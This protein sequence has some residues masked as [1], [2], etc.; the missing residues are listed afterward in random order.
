MR[1]GFQGDLLPSS[2]KRTS[3]PEA[4]TALT[5]I[6]LDEIE[7]LLGTAAGKSRAQNAPAAAQ[8]RLGAV[9]LLHR[10]GSAL[11]RHV[12]RHARVTDGVFVAADS[13][14]GVAFLPARPL[15]EVDRARRPGRHPPLAI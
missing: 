4:V 5:S 15:A 2:S 10:F 9:S 13:P 7:R 11:D 12:H 3:R 6:F 1:L 8:P 14:D